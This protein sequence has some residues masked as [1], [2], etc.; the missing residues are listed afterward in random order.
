MIKKIVSYLRW[1][2]I[3][4]TPKKSQIIFTPLKFL[5]F[6]FKSKIMK[7]I[8]SVNARNFPL[9]LE[10]P[11]IHTKYEFHD[12]S[13]NL[14]FRWTIPQIIFIQPIYDFRNFSPK[15]TRNLSL[16]WSLLDHAQS[17]FLHDWK[18]RKLY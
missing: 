17:K 14:L 11:K 2:I 7:I 8:N 6:I 9:N 18:S 1:V 10:Y 5:N 3:V 12:F 13:L 4:L 16:L 15:I